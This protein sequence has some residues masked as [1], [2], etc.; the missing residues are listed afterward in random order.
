VKAFILLG[1][2]G[3]VVLMGAIMGAAGA[4][5]QAQAGQPGMFTPGAA[6]DLDKDQ[7]AQASR[8]LT[9]ADDLKAPPLAVLAMVCAA[10]GESDFRPVKNGSGSKYA[11]V[12]QADPANIPMADTEGQA[13][14][15]QLGGKGFQAG[16][17]IFLATHHPHWTPGLI[18]TMV[19]ASGQPA[20]FYDV[21][22]PQAEKII[23]AW[24]AGS[25]SILTPVN[26]D[27][28]AMLNEAGVVLTPGQRADF[29]SGGIDPRLVSLLAMI[30][31][32]H[33]VIVTALRHDHSTNTV[34]GNRSNHADGRAMDIGSVDGQPCVAT[35]GGPQLWGSACGRLLR[36]LVDL[37]PPLRPTEL[38]YCWDPDGPADPRGFARSDH[39][40]HIHAAFDLG[41]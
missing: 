19:E 37:D 1:G 40:T 11:G 36:Q 24:H 2:I 13:K 27:V 41:T 6:L 38:I 16:G 5:V 17:A 3:V 14:A 39:C 9:V 33:T 20:S 29:Q 7:T 8:A 4:S 23:A 18:A 21:H 22:R 10:L 28:G 35:W 26:A 25:G 32:T 31:E 30:G 12:F 34:E 15:F